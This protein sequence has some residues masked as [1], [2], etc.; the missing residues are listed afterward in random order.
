MEDWPIVHTDTLYKCR[1]SH[2]VQAKSTPQIIDLSCALSGLNTLHDVA[3]K[4]CSL[5]SCHA[6]VDQ[7]NLQMLLNHS[8]WL[9]QCTQGSDLR[10]VRVKYS[11][12]IWMALVNWPADA[13]SQ[14]KERHTLHASHKKNLKKV[15]DWQ[16]L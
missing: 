13:H 10:L 9:L 12:C 4:H 5:S 16:Q 8:L 2:V 11:K 15:L 1:C 7:L 6:G 14:V 3:G